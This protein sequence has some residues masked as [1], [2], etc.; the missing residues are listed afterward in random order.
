[1]I[2][3]FGGEGLVFRV[4]IICYLKRLVFIENY[5]QLCKEIV[6]YGLNRKKKLVIE[7][8]VFL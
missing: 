4:V 6:K 5:E 1:M 8:F 3:G 7:Y 2:I